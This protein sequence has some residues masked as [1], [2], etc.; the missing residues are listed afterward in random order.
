MLY[1]KRWDAKVGAPTLADF[2][3]WL[4]TKNPAESYSFYECEG[5][6]LMGQ[7]MANRGIPWTGA[8]FHYNGDWEGSSYAQTGRAIFGPGQFT[9]ISYRPHTFGAALKRAR[10][11]RDGAA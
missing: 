9:A 2:I 11:L 4:E 3:A 1:D 6:C 10:K 8:P 5:R 7:Y